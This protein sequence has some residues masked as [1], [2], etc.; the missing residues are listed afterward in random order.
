MKPAAGAAGKP[1][2]AAQTPAGAPPA[3]AAPAAAT[4]VVATPIPAAGAAETKGPLRRSLN[5]DPRG[6]HGRPWRQP[7][8]HP[9]KSRTPMQLVATLELP[10]KAVRDLTIEDLS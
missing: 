3:A 5:A 9:T 8:P 10:V 1:T 7:L 6:P 4:P 2:W